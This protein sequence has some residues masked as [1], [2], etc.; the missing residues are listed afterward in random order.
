MYS[1]PTRFTMLANSQ[2]QRITSIAEA[3]SLS[4]SHDAGAVALVK[5]RG[6]KRNTGSA[7]AIMLFN[8]VHAQIVSCR[9]LLQVYRQEG[10]RCGRLIMRLRSR[11]Q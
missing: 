8:A 1:T 3:S 5:Y 7:V 4:G 9:Q 6:K 2:R 10:L 11:F